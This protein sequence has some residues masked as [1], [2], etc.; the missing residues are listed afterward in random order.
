V[1]LVLIVQGVI[2]D[3]YLSLGALS[4][5]GLAGLVLATRLPARL[6]GG[7]GPGRP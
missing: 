5:A 1:V 4:V 7:T 2:S 6:A 3:P